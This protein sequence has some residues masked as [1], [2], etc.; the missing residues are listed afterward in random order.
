MGLRTG[1]GVPLH[2]S[3]HAGNQRGGGKES[4]FLSL[5]YSSP[6]KENA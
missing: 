2:A 5:S 4:I 3:I 6:K 1:D